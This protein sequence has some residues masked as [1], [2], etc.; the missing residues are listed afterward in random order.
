MSIELMMYRTEQGNKTVMV[1]DSGRKYLSVLIM[2]GNLTVR[3]VP[4]AEARF[5]SPL[6][7]KP[8]AMSTRVRQYRAYGRRNGMTKAAKSFLTKA[9]A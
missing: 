7:G 8:K 1:D 3:K 6:L 2:D 5:M 9:A 4:K